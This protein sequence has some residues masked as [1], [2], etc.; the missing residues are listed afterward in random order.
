MVPA[1]G[2]ESVA[3]QIAE[4]QAAHARHVLDLAELQR[5]R[6][7]LE[8]RMQWVS[9]RASVNALGG[10]FAQTLS[11]YLA[12]LPRHEQFEVGGGAKGRAHRCGQR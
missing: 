11:A 6:H 1:P 5:D 12:Q 7:D 4:A 9:R 3:Q 10:E 8:Q 2:N